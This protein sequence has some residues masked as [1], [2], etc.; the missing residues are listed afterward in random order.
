MAAIMLIDDSRTVFLA[1]QAELQVDRHTVHHLA[2]PIDA[3]R[4]LKENHIDLILLDLQMPTFSGFGIGAL[5]RNFDKKRTPILVYSS[6]PL[7]E[8]AAIASK[9]GAVGY[10]GKEQPMEE[11]RRLIGSIVRHRAA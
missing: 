11:L 2:A 4:Y 6:R 8:L 10:L 7:P 5:L 9:I 3:P 1:V